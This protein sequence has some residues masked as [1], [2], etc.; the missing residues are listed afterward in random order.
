MTGWDGVVVIVATEPER[1]P[2]VF[3]EL[4][5]VVASSTGGLLVV[6]EKPAPWPGG[7]VI[8]L[9]LRRNSDGAVGAQCWLGPIGAGQEQDAL[10]S[11]LRAGGP[12]RTPVPRALAHRVLR[13]RPALQTAN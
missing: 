1:S 4:K 10:V 2:G 5:S 9:Q 12:G 7:P 13:P 3:A 11:W 6:L 8:G